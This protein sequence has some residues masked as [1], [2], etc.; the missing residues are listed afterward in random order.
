MFSLRRYCKNSS[1]CQW[2]T[3]HAK[4]KKNITISQPKAAPTKPNRTK[5]WKA[6]GA[7]DNN[8]TETSFP[9][10]ESVVN[11]YYNAGGYGAPN[12]QNRKQIALTKNKKSLSTI[13]SIWVNSTHYA[14]G[15]SSK[16]QSRLEANVGTLDRIARLKAEAIANSK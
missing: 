9:N 6:K 10:Q 15:Y 5:A 3:D 11:K 14:I 13:N 2:R 16:E 7:D 4:F 1:I 12:S 8:I